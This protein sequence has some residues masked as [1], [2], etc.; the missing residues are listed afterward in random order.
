M[1]F[2]GSWVIDSG[3]TDHMTHS[4]QKFSTY[5]PCPSNKN[6]ATVVGQGEVH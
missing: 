1:S 5:N 3:A 4:T 2:L 6:I